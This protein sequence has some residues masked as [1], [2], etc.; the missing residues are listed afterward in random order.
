MIHQN[1][2]H[3]SG[4]DS[5]KVRSI[6]RVK[7]A[8]IHQPQVRLID[9]R[10]ALQCVFRTLPLEMIASDLAKFLVD[11]RN[12]TLEGGLIARLPA[13]KQFGDRLGMCLIHNQLGP[14]TEWTKDSFSTPAESTKTLSQKVRPRSPP[15][16]HSFLSSFM[17]RFPS[18]FPQL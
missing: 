2:T 17:N 7:R 8:L 9:Q 18:R 4:G 14:Q 1:L 3:Q 11:Q 12:Q 13:R 15:D 6:V 16:P 10:S 5:E